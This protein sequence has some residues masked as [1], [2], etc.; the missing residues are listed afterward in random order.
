MEPAEVP[1]KK[2]G[3]SRSLISI[4]LTFVAFSL[5]IGLALI[6]DF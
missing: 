6:K 5:S 4:I 3:S 2:A 1:E